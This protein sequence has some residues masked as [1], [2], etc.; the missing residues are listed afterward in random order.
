MKINLKPVRNWFGYT[1]G[2]RRSS[3]ILLLI[4]ILVI[5]IR[6]TIPE[7]NITVEEISGNISG[8]DS[9][10]NERSSREQLFLFDPDNASYDTL[11]KL[12][13][14]EKEANKIV[15]YRN[16]GGK[17]KRPGEIKK[18]D[19]VGKDKAKKFIPYVKVNS[20]TTGQ[21]LSVSY[22]KKSTILDINNCDSAS[23]ERLSGIGPVLAARIIKYRHLL[24]GFAR[25]SQL[26]EVYGLTQETYNLIE[27]SLYV[28][29]L[30]ITSIK[31]NSADYKELVRFPYFERYEITAIL[32]YRELEGKLTGISD[33][34][35]NKLVTKEKAA[36]IVPYLNFE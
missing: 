1:R 15:K 19:G 14:T 9:L 6:Y 10:S 12:G 25:I 30:V 2:E 23:L 21:V 24:G 29:S 22:Q 27:G 26:K 5:T 16:K 3:F 36:K 11:V 34:V 33:L 31:I 28:D 35:E 7:N 4:I 17:F 20:I 13:F 18:V 8:I 32:K